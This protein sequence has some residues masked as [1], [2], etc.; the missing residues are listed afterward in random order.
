MRAL[1]KQRPILSIIGAVAAVVLASCGGGDGRAEAAG[2]GPLDEFFGDGAIEFE[3]GGGMS[4]SFGSTVVGDFEFSDEQLQQM[5]DTE[6]FVAEC[7]AGEGFEYTAN[8]INPEDW[9]DPWSEAQALAPDEFAEQYGYGITTMRFDD[10]DLPADPNQEYRESLSSE[11]QEA[12]ERALYG[13][14]MEWEGDEPPP[15]EDRGCY[16]IASAEIYDEDPYETYDEGNDP[17]AEF[18][19]LMNDISTLSER[20]RTDQRLEEAEQA[21]L[22]CMADAGY[23]EFEFVGDAEQSVY[24]RQ[25]ELEGWDEIDQLYESGDFE[26]AE[27]LAESFEPR[28]PDPQELAELQ[29]Y[30]IELAV[31]DRGC[32]TEHYDA[33]YT[34]VSHAMQDEFIAEHRSELE[35]YRDWAEENDYDGGFGFG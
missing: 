9:T 8:V 26:E 19:G 14:T 11:A 22:G 1:P 18:E 33:V 5:R 23:P 7:M 27:E 30:E 4:M 16:G 13:Y 21:W 24:Q 17:W 32:M 2:G 31:I 28:E 20:I 12:Y 3:P 35:R 34:E 10:A 29:E 6:E 25:N 15:V